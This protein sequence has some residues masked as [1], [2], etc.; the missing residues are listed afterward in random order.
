MIKLRSLAAALLV[1]AFAGAVSQGMAQE[2]VSGRAGRQLIERRE[3]LPF[4][5]ALRRAGI[6]HNQLVDRQLCR[7]G[8][9]YVYRLRVLGPGGRVRGIDIPAR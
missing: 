4:P 5:D 7:G 8:G 2:C 3:V 1:L 9:G 6:A